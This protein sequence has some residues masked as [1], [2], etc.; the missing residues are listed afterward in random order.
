MSMNE[1]GIHN[2][3]FIDSLSSYFPY[4]V[5]RLHCKACLDGG[6]DHN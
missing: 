5:S 6:L 3:G 4:H 2:K 1:S